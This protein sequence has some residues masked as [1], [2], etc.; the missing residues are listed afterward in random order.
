MTPSTGL[1]LHRLHGRADRRL[2]AR[3]QSL[4]LMTERDTA[5]RV[6]LAQPPEHCHSLDDYPGCDLRRLRP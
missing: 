6:R 2:F 3:I 5:V 1:P 4:E